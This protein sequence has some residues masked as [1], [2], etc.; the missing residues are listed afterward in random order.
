LLAL[1]SISTLRAHCPRLL[2]F[3]LGR[4][5]Q[6]LHQ[7]W[8]KITRYLIGISRADWH[9]STQHTPLPSSEPCPAGDSSIVS[10]S[11]PDDLLNDSNV[12]AMQ[13]VLQVRR[14][15]CARRDAGRRPWYCPKLAWS[16]P[17]AV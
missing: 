3:V 17:T 2:A 4:A 8:P 10:H 7:P 15:S 14:W 6:R 16:R 9:S 12:S 11:N 13:G 5:S 1:G